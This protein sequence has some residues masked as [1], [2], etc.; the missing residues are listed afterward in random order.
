MG[1]VLDG[2][3]LTDNQKRGLLACLG[4]PGC[5]MVVTKSR[6]RDAGLSEDEVEDLVRKGYLESLTDGGYLIPASVKG[7]AIIIRLCEQ[8]NDDTI[9]QMI[10]RMPHFKAS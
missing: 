8:S 9:R 1:K 6:L 10:S 5:A 7:N 2:H 4:T 3:D